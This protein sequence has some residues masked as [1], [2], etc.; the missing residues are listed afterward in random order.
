MRLLRLELENLNS[1]YGAHTVDFQADLLEAPLFLISGS[2]GSGK[3]T[4][5]DAIS[6]ALFGVT[7]RLRPVGGLE[8][9]ADQEP[10]HALS[11]STAL[12]R[13]ALEFRKS[14]QSA[15]SATYRAVWEVWRGDRR[16]PKPGGK[17]HG[18][19]RWLHR[20]D[21]STAKWNQ[22]ATDY[23]SEHGRVRDLE[24][25]LSEA[26]E[27]FTLADFSRCMLLAQGDFAAFLKATE[28]ERS[29][30]L[31][32]LTRTEQYRDIGA[33]AA[34]RL[35]QAKDKAMAASGAL[36]AVAV[37]T[38]EQLTALEKEL[39]DSEKAAQAAQEMAL[40]AQACLQWFDANEG[41]GAE[42]DAARA[43]LAQAQQ[44][45]DSEATPLLRLAAFEEARTALSQLA[46]VL[47]R[48]GALRAL[49]E[50]FQQ[51][52][53]EAQGRA[54]ELVL[55]QAEEERALLSLAEAKRELAEQEPELIR[56]RDLRTAWRAAQREQETAASK[57]AQA[58]ASLVAAEARSK[59]SAAAKCEKEQALV[60]ANET[61]AASPWESVTLALPALAV[62][63]RAFEERS[64]YAR[65]Q[66][67][68]LEE[69]GAQTQE[70]EEDAAQTREV[71][72]ASAVRLAE[73]AIPAEARRAALEE[74]LEQGDDPHAALRKLELETERLLHRELALKDV[75]RQLEEVRQARAAAVEHEKLVETAL[76]V[77]TDA[78]QRAA[79]AE[80]DKLAAERNAEELDKTLA[81]LRWA[82]HLS[83]QRTQLVEGSPCPLC[84]SSEH[85]AVLHPEQ[86][87]KDEEALAQCARLEGA[88]EQAERMRREATAHCKKLEK[89][90]AQ[91]HLALGLAQS[92]AQ[93]CRK[94]MTITQT[95]AEQLAQAFG[96]EAEAAQV[97]AAREAVQGLRRELETRRE[98]VSEAWAAARA[99]REAL[100]EGQRG[101][102]EAAVRAR[103]TETKLAHHRARFTDESGRLLVARHAVDAVAIELGAQLS[104]LGLPPEPMAGLAEARRRDVAHRAAR[105]DWEKAQAALREVMADCGAAE[106]AREEKARSAAALAEEA[107]S[108]RASSEDA[109]EEVGRCLGGA[110]PET[111]HE[112]HRARIQACEEASQL[113]Q[114]TREGCG[115]ASAKGEAALEEVSQTLAEETAGLREDE[116]AFAQQVKRHG[117]EEALRAK[118]LTD[119]EVVSLWNLRNELEEAL[120]GAQA[121]VMV[122]QQ[123]VVA[124]QEKKPAD[125]ELDK[126]REPLEAQH[127]Q[128]AAADRLHRDAAAEVRAKL[129]AK[130]KA[131][132]Q[133]AEALRALEAANAEQSLWHRM[134]ELI[135][136]NDGEAFRKF[137]QVLNLRELLSRANA[138]LVRLRPRYRLVPAKDAEGQER[139]AFA[140]LDSAHAGEERPI[141]TLSGGETFLVSLALAL[142]LSDYR[143]VRM[144][145]ETLLLDEGF[146]T[147][148]PDTLSDVLGTLSALTSQG[149]QVGIISHVEVLREK[150]PASILIE[151]V[152]EGRSRV[153][154]CSG[155]G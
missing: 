27:G 107:A 40:E 84:G 124:H 150:I 82:T 64:A 65:R 131:R 123:Q 31:E 19:Y 25:A 35:R 93:D 60:L 43:R 102:H 46:V 24:A 74:L 54:A 91:A 49:E 92:K 12:G 13:C 34:Q 151:P 97:A 59:E 52:R 39:L 78:E 140:V 42:Q 138:R 103:E 17:I 118:A 72:S 104:S 20:L 75:A 145:I 101:A 110:D 98:R 70:C 41:L 7:P 132:A 63:G 18:P 50:R 147:L 73:Q 139:L 116:D 10:H 120:R 94:R 90:L 61:L 47:R 67:E 137:A 23:P 126:G 112:G 105:G 99:A 14:C 155:M 109:T 26:L 152:G 85:P 4:L 153:R 142:A 146:G 149:T 83:T 29:A 1:L 55:A 5:L 79:R 6:L 22:L 100:D 56:A 16:N 122:R 144:P 57:L 48:R 113:A 36:G 44:A 15:P 8:N 134:N 114:A 66:Q 125:L 69:L 95:S 96:V 21:D 133:H 71:A 38:V 89:E 121:E 128:A 88:K 76:V 51:R 77:W 62:L 108:R 87:S 130:V 106:L 143:T 2:T 154:V 136:K 68:I 129:A 86:A 9:R 3:S 127:A 37:A 28:A 81:A 115:G 80:Q 11:R 53:G 32:R 117:D 58:Q 148:D 141:S 33:R 111:L 30:I 135:G 119:D 45:M